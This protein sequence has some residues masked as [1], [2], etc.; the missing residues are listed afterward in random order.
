[1][2]ILFPSGG[3]GNQMFMVAAVY[4]FARTFG[5]RWYVD[6]D[7]HQLVQGNTIKN[8]IG[9]VFRKV[10]IYDLSRKLLIEDLYKQGYNKAIF[11]DEQT[12]WARYNLDPKDKNLIYEVHD[13]V[14]MSYKYFDHYREQILELFKLS[15]EDNQEIDSFIK[16]ELIKDLEIP[17]VSLHVRRTDYLSFSDIYPTMSVDYYLRAQKKIIEQTQLKE[18]KAIIFSDDIEWCKQNLKF[19]NQCKF[20]A[21]IGNELPDFVAMQIMARCDHN[22]IGN[23]TFSWWG[24]YLNTNPN[25]VWVSPSIWFKK[26]NMNVDDILPDYVHQVDIADLI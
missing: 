24:A 8:Y 3:L 10:P 14:F 9:N 17:L 25:K 1:M 11:A 12:H 18:F 7:D 20:I 5:Q 26:D 2:F 6:I 13:S 19:V 22:I 16:R 15:E 4:S 23:S 21:Y